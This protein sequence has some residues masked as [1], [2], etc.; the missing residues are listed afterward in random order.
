MM[1]KKS[2]AASSRIY[3]RIPPEHSGVQVNHCKSPGCVNYGIAAEQKSVPGS[4]R[5]TLEGKRGI[6][7][8]RCTSCGVEFP[9]KSNIGIVEEAGRLASYLPPPAPLCCPNEDS[10]EAA[11]RFRGYPARGRGALLAIEFDRCFG[12]RSILLICYAA[13]QPGMRMHRGVQRA[14]VLLLNAPL[15]TVVFPVS[16][17]ALD[18]SPWSSLLLSGPRSVFADGLAVELDPVGVVDDAV[19]DGVRV[20]GLADKFVPFVHG[21]LAGDDGGAPAIALLNDLQKVLAGG[22]VERPKAE[23]VQDEHIDPRQRPE[24]PGMAAIAAGER[25]IAEQLRH[26]LIED[27]AVVAARFVAKGASQPRLAEPGLAANNQVVMDADPVTGDKLP[28]HGPV[29]I[30]GMLVVDI[31]HHGLVSQIGVLQP[32][33]QPFVAAMAYLTVQQ[34]AEPFG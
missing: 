7:S 32:R 16:A 15:P 33:R 9:L 11:H 19:E 31:F 8:C 14:G 13:T 20:G 22:G 26:A 10:G 17:V 1:Q 24:Q 25:Q 34:Q 21:R 4:N 23:I 28:E 12:R 5:Y 27:G 2:S 29:E 3:P 30:A 6:S 18:A